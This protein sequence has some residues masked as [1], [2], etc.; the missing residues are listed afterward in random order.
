[1][2]LTAAATQESGVSARLPDSGLPDI[3][4]APDLSNLPKGMTA[5]DP[6]TGKKFNRP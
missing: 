3:V 2:L 6:E 5:V 1:M 4:I